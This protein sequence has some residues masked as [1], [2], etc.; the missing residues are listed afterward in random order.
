MSVTESLVW[1]L[2]GEDLVGE[3][4]SWQ[5]TCVSLHEV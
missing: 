2:A 5:T 4:Y 3:D 1:A